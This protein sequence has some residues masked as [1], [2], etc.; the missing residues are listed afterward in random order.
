MFPFHL[1]GGGKR[2]RATLAFGSNMLGM[3]TP[4]SILIPGMWPSGRVCNRE[5]DFR[6]SPWQQGELGETSAGSQ[7]SLSG[8]QI[9]TAI[10]QL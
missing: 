9:L 3:E 1:Q 5:A 4:R 2:R 6:R 10:L 7:T 8:S